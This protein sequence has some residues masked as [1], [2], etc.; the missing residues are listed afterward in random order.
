[1]DNIYATYVG[2][3]AFVN[4]VPTRNLT[5]SDWDELTAEQRKN[6][7]DLKLYR[8]IAPARDEPL[9]EVVKENKR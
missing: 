4:G 9:R 1:M 7:V 8:V 2:N 6:A 3:G 5:K